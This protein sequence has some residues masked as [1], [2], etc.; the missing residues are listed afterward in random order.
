MS[1]RQQSPY[2]S[3]AR[4]WLA[5]VERRQQNLIEL[6]N[7]GRWR[8]YYTH[9]QF[10]DEIRKVLHLRNQWAWLAGLPVSEQTDFQPNIKQSIRHKQEFGAQEATPLSHSAL[11]QRR[12][13]A[14]AIL[15]A[16]AGRL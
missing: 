8:H 15:A 1:G 11:G 7:T 16:V 10:L 5:L 12:R 13:P 3:I 4:R 6:C 2:D 14:S 9:A